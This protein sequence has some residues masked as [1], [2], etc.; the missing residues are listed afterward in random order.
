MGS[1]VKKAIKGYFN[2]LYQHLPKRTKKIQENNQ[3]S[4]WEVK[5]GPP[6]HKTSVCFKFP[7][8]PMKQSSQWSP[9]VLHS[10]EKNYR[11]KPFSFHYEN[12]AYLLLKSHE[13]CK[14]CSTRLSTSTLHKTHLDS[15][16]PCTVLTVLSSEHIAQKYEYYTYTHACM[17]G[18]HTAF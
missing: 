12:T 3:S 8:I 5:W 1:I 11:N 16:T 9:W 4:S 6:G 2:V 10:L 14:K 15:N 18:W 17:H 13:D 7:E